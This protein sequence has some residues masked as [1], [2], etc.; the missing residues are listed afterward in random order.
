MLQHGKQLHRYNTMTITASFPNLP[1]SLNLDFANS[2]VLDN[3]ITFTRSTTGT[4]YNGYSSAVAEQNL[5]T[6]SQ[7]IASWIAFNVTTASNIV[8]A[9]DG[10]T[11]GGRLTCSAG[12]SIHGA[13]ITPTANPCV[14]NTNYTLSVYLQAGTNSF[15]TVVFST[16]ATCWVAVTANLTTG[17]ITKTGTGAT[18]TLVASSITAVGSWYRVVLTATLIGTPCYSEVDVA[19][20]ATP[21]YGS[22][23]EE[24]WTALGTET[25]YAWGAQLE[26][27]SAVTAYNATTTTAITNYIPVLQTGA[28]NQAR[29]DHNPTTGESLG[30]LIEQQSTNLLTYSQTLSNAIWATTGVTNNATANIAPDGTQTAGLI[31]EDTSTGQH[32]LTNTAFTTVIGTTYS[33]SV[34]LKAGGRTWAAIQYVGSG[35]STPILFVNLST[36]VL[37]T[38]TGTATASISS[39]GNGWYKVTLSCLADATVSALRIYTAT[40]DGTS[41]PSYTGNGYSG[42]YIWGAQV[43]ALAFPTSYIPTVA[44]QVTRS[45]D[46]AS[47]TGTNFSSWY[48]NAQGSV[49]MEYSTILPSN[50]NNPFYI[51]DGTLNNAYYSQ[52]T[53]TAINVYVKQNNSVISSGLSISSA[54]TSNVFAKQAISWSNTAIINS[55]A[56]SSAS[57]SINGVVSNITRLDFSGSTP[58]TSA[59]NGRM[60]KFAYYPIAC[61]SAQ[62]QALTGS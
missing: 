46:S 39:V 42:I 5:L 58:T 22:Y 50:A 6:N 17:V 37:G 19:S 2:G 61:T 51:S 53:S 33:N 13:V 32:R 24:T 47:M 49:L 57:Q 52:Q 59:L 4:Y 36:G 62:L 27:R 21:T 11:T 28:I 3:R 25:I 10:T 23:G 1:C 15:A 45:A 38:L 8:A 29:F 56:G 26:Q 30:L 18:G 55:V 60:K 41:G 35:G 12:A 54:Q 9:P 43:E 48:N 40:S 14:T 20:S 31:S 7:T 44:S 16:T 34:Y